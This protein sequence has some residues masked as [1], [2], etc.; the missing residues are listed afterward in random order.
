MATRAFG[1][2]TLVASKPNPNPKHLDGASRS[3]R[4]PSPNRLHQ[5]VEVDSRA[6]VRRSNL[7][8]T[9]TLSSTHQT[10]D[11]GSTRDVG[12]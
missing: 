10:R 1:P 8:L 11:V 6:R 5:M 12:R 7:N 9:S 2:S 4:E 3:S